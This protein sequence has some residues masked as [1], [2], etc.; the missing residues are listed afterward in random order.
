MI[1]Y[2]RQWGEKMI[3][4]FKIIGG[5]YYLQVNKEG[6]L[7]RLPPLRWYCVVWLYAKSRFSKIHINEVEALIK[8]DW[9]RSTWFIKNK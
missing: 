8:K 1:I 4:E 7:Q 3:G 9:C 5:N 2:L 6:T